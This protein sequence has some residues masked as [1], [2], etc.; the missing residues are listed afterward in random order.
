MKFAIFGNR[1]QSKKSENIDKLFAAINEWKDSFYIDRSFYEYLLEEDRLFMQPEGIIEGDDF[2]ADIAISFGGD[3]TFLRTANRVGSKD[4]PLLGI[5]AGRLGFLTSYSAN[6]VQELFE[7]L[8]RGE[9]DIEERGVIK[10]EASD[11]EF[12]ESPYALNEIAVM[13]HENSSMISIEV[14]L[15][16]KELITYQA[17]GLIIAPP[18]GSTGYSLSAGGPIIAPDAS[19]FVLTPIASHSLNA[20]PVVVNDRTRITL[21]VASRSHNYL[22][23]IDGRNESCNECTT[24]TL[25]KADHNIKIVRIK[26]QTFFKTLHDKMMWGADIRN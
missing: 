26:G 5:N 22:V 7:Y 13:K 23:A 1:H 15:D 25:R 8:H 12:A 17:D 24:L 10:V 6:K 9:Y 14:S 16:S 11:K 3:G 19:V 20:R 18:S 2:D 4:I 21:K